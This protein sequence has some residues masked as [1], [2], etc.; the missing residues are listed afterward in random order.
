MKKVLFVT[1]GGG[2]IKMTLPVAEGLADSAKAQVVVLGLTTAAPQVRAAGL[3]LVR[4]CD[5]IDTGNPGDAKALVWGEQL[6]RD[7]DKNSAVDHAETVAY[8]G[9]C[10]HELVE[11]VGLIAAQEMYKRNG[12]HAFLPVKT[13]ARMLALVKPD[14]VVTTNSPRAER[15]AVLAAKRV[16][17]PAVCMVDLF[18]KDEV[19]WIGA[20][21]YADSVCVLNDSV[22]KFLVAAGRD[23]SQIHVTGNPNFDALCE[24]SLKARGIALRTRCGWGGKS[25]ILWPCVDEPAVHPF[26]GTAGEPEVPVRA[27]S[28]LVNFVMSRADFVLCVRPRPG[29]PAPG[30]PAD[31]R[32]L[33][34]G[35]DWALPELL[36]AVD[37]VVAMNSTIAVEAYFAGAHVIKLLGSV[38]DDA[39]PLVEYGLAQEQATIDNI[40]PAVLRIGKLPDRRALQPEPATERVLR[41][42]EAYL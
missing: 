4:F 2:H 31:D 27:L 10:F 8:L 12:R 17:I 29:Y 18:A 41:V 1:Y 14:V 32:V 40:G 21:D 11:D 35:Q 15:A 9:L 5:L 7:M 42:I 39:M 33:L 13:M 19:S 38:F 20:K 36:S 28:A 37:M 34:T 26:N 23:A 24:P 3:D 30:L 6:A 16:G 22:K 25:V